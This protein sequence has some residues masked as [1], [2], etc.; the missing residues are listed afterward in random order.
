MGTYLGFTVRNKYIAY[1]A[2][3]NTSISKIGIL[4]LNSANIHGD[5][6]TTCQLLRVK[7][8]DSTV[9]TAIESKLNRA[10]QLDKAIERCRIATILEC[11]VNQT[12]NTK[13]QQIDP[14]QVRK[15]VSNAYKIKII[16]RE[17]L[18]NFVAKNVCHS[19]HRYQAFPY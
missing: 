6:A 18:H 10:N 4:Q 9:L 7:L 17:D 5:I 1:C 13:T 19:S 8:L 3:R 11:Q 14:V 15:S 12:F 2:I 16:S